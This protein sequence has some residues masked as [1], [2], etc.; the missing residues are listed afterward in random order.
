M[1]KSLFL[2][3][4][5]ASR[6]ISQNKSIDGYGRIYYKANED[7]INPCLDVDFQ[8]K[9][10]LA[11]LSSADH[12]LTARFLDANNVDAFDINRIT[13]YYFYLRIWTIKYRNTLYPK[14]L[15][16]DKNWLGSLL[17][18]ITPTNSAEKNALD[19][20]KKHLK[21]NTNLINLF[22]DVDVQPKGQTLYTSPSDLEDCLYP[23]LNFYQIDLFKKF[24]LH[25]TYDI[26]MISNILE[27]AHNDA[28]KLTIAAENL[29]TILRSGGSVL[30]SSLIHRSL[31]SLA[32]EKEIFSDLFYFDGNPQSYQYIRK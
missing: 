5:L 29:G 6:L 10:V 24:H 26:I 28:S 12:V 20:F 15:N 32:K 30:C 13:I 22:Y 1:E 25:D 7:L 9:D 2:K 19:F 18:Q 3:D 8:N 16:G 14:I 11:V 21:D 17:S 31:E 27:W 23:D 4:Y